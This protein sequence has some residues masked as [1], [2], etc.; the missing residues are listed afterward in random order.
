V[1][2]EG[3]QLF[4]SFVA[5]LLAS[6]DQAL[7]LVS[8]LDE[9]RG[10]LLAREGI[11]GTSDPRLA[12]ENATE[13]DLMITQR[14]ADEARELG[15]TVFQ[16]DRPLKAMIKRAAEHFG[17]AIDR[18]RRGGDLAAV[19]RFENEVDATQVRLYRESLGEHAPEDTPIAFA[20][21]CGAPGCDAV[22]ELP[23]GS[24]GER[25]VVAHP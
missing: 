21:E 9:Q 1:I 10:R 19:R 20:C 23:L 14:F 11:L 17:P 16:V 2:V 15:L 24:Y 22:V 3:P 18:G 8:P 25:P 7:F 5:P 4:P 12:R 13:R 6:P